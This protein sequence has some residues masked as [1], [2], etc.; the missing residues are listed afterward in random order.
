V[1]SPLLFVVSVLVGAA[2]LFALD[3]YRMDLIG[4]GALTLLLLGG[5]LSVPEALAGFADPTVHMIGGL[6]IVGGAVFQTG[7]A[8]RFGKQ[9]ER[10]G[11]GSQRKLMLVIM[12]A[13][14]SLSAFLSSTGTVA[15]MV[16]VVAVLAR[17]SQVSPS[18]LM[19]PLAYATLL[20]GLLTLIAT[21]PNLIVSNALVKHGFAPFGFFDFTAPA[22]CLL[23]V[24]IC[25]ILFFVDRLL[26]ERLSPGGT[27]RTA[28]PQELW[29]RYGLEGWVC[30]C[31]I[32]SGSPLV[33]RSIAQ[34][35]VRSLYSVAIFAVRSVTSEHSN[36]D[37]NIE[38]ARADRVLL[39]GDVLTVKGA[40]DNVERFV[41]QA[42][43]ERLDVLKELPPELVTGE[44]LI[45]PGSPLVGKTIADSQ[46]RTRFDVT[47]SAVFRSQQVLRE[48]V[49]RTTV[50]VG[51]LLLLLGNAKSVTKLRDEL[52]EAIL[53]N[54]SEVLKR[55][56]FHTDKAPVALTVLGCMLLAMAFEVVAPVVAV[57]TAAV[58][59]V[60]FGCLEAKQ[61][62]RQINLESVFLIATILPMA[63]ALNKVG[64]VDAVVSG[65]LSTFGAAGPYVILSAV[66]FLTA[67]VGL[68]ISNTAT[69]V[70]VSPVAAQ[71]AASLSI[72]PQ[73]LLMAV[74]VAASSAFVTPVSTPVN[75]L[76]VNPGGY[77]FTDF[78]RL[79]L[80][81]LIVTWLASL[82]VL[83]LFFPF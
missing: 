82:I 61:A 50:Q 26:P 37:G 63:T 9:L 68:F 29:T 8:D 21:P 58:A 10:L 11:A 49:A 12:L 78:A 60:V 62:E 7:L 65:L 6:F 42:Q 13:A 56:A 41:E 20:G 28:T 70:L 23:A 14:A 19:I 53:V 35:Q 73:A 22:L 36:T 5:V 27:E 44:L 48:S 71:L 46:L 39:A 81:L 40:P 59:M 54:E 67:G 72:Q 30:E 57:I 79:G 69:A 80:P 55:A 66:F 3:R 52:P 74:A 25:F 32:L 45:A 1:I 24:G 18:K 75:M 4:F 83:P 34:S 76:V 17:R 16:P 77:K 15:L 43:L 33:G 47:V 31:R 51:D 2:A 64:A 38:R